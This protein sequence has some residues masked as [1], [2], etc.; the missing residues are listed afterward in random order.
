MICQVC[1]VEAPTKKV[2]FY[3]NIGVFIVRF[4]KSLDGQL[5]KK[6]IHQ[7]FWSMTGTT[8]LLGWWGTISMIVSPFMILNN[9]GRYLGC[10]RLPRVPQ[11]AQIPILT[12]EIIDRIDPFA[13]D[14]FRRLNRGEEVDTVATSIAR[15]AQVTPGE[16]LLYLHRVIDADKTNEK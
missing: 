2:I 10:L 1:G 9:I 4:P 8:L 11:S 16:V 14:L 5:C 13:D 3:Q 12:K 15:S 6:C 7:N